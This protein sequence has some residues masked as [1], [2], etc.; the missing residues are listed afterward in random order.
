[1]KFLNKTMLVGLTLSAALLISPATGYANAI[2]HSEYTNSGVVESEI[3][4]SLSLDRSVNKTGNQV[5]IMAASAVQR[6]TI[7]QYQGSFL[8]YAYSKLEWKYDGTKIVWDY[9]TQEV[10][11]VFPNNITKDGIVTV[12][13]SSSHKRY[14]YKYTAGAG[15]VSP[16]GNVNVYNLPAV[17]T[18]NFYGTGSYN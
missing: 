6:K 14:D 2:E 4:N 7:E 12:E 17:H 18:F 10:G 16:W 9:P 8:M 11:W 1:M 15:V 3:I 13:S 5:G